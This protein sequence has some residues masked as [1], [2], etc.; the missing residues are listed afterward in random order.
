MLF[1]RGLQWYEVGSDDAH[2]TDSL[3]FFAAASQQSNWQCNRRRVEERSVDSGFRESG[4]VDFVF[5]F[6]VEFVVGSIIII[7]CIIFAIT[8]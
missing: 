5:N 7:E 4:E 2:T 8:F 1:E 3:L 6:V